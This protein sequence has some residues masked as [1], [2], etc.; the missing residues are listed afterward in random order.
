MIGPASKH[1]IFIHLSLYYLCQVNC[2]ELLPSPLSVSSLFV[3][4]VLDVNE[5][6]YNLSISSQT[7]NE[8]ESPGELVSMLSVRDPDFP[9]REEQVFPN[10]IA[11]NK[12]AFE[13]F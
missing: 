10:C 8:N 3:I 9:V 4:I 5:A 1:L 12:N 11:V 7:V 13:S 6:P 2:S